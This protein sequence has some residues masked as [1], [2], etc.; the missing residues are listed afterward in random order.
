MAM[1]DFFSVVMMMTMMM[2]TGSLEAIE[3]DR[4]WNF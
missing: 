1:Y 2:R 3:S 4:S